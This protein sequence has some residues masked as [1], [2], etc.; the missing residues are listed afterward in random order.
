MSFADNA[1][2]AAEG[3][4]LKEAAYKAKNLMERKSR[5]GEWA[6]EIKQV[7]REHEEKRKT[8]KDEETIEKKPAITRSQPTAG[9]SKPKATA[10]TSVSKPTVV[11]SK[12]PPV[13]SKSKEN[14]LVPLEAMVE[15]SRSEGEKGNEVETQEEVELLQPST[16]TG[17]PPSLLQPE[18]YFFLPRGLELPVMAQQGHTRLM[19]SQDCTRAMMDMWEERLEEQR[20]QFKLVRQEM[21]GGIWEH[22]LVYYVWECKLVLAWQK[23]SRMAPNTFPD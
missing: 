2:V 9:L 22:N 12:P 15:T 7:K 6:R 19:R 23:E 1:I 21:I 16:Q 14:T 18:D 13:V 20:Q 8:G 3:K 4:D 5:A 17:P 10:S 11:I